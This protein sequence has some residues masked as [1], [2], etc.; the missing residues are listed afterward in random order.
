[1][2]YIIEEAELEPLE[3]S[4]N[5]KRSEAQALLQDN[6]SDNEPINNFV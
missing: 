4:D 6:L 3:D 1:M 2:N 5:E